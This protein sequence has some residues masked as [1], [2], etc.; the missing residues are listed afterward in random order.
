MPMPQSHKQAALSLAHE[1]ELLA[2]M[3]T[4]PQIQKMLDDLHDN[5]EARRQAATNLPHYLEHMGVRLP[6]GVK[7]RFWSDNWFLGLTTKNWRLGYDS[8]GG[9]CFFC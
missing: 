8:D 5:P 2:K 1:H 4:D 7:A 6:S 9:W 3:I